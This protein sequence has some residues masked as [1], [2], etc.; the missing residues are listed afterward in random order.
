MSYAEVQC[1]EKTLPHLFPLFGLSLRTQEQCF[2][3]LALIARTTTSNHPLFPYLLS[4]LLCLRITNPGLYAQYCR[5]SASPKEVM[6]YLRTLS[7]GETFVDSHLGRVCEAFLIIGIPDEHQRNAARKECQE[8]AD[9]TDRART[10]F[11]ILTSFSP[12]GNITGYLF[13][14]IE[15]TQRFVKPETAS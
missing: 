1:L 7:S 4:V 10:I 3:Q 12:G 14:K 2:T 8:L 11:E 13:N 6:K 15:L 9:T 5:G